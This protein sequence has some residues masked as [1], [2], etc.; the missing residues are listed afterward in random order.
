M[1]PPILKLELTIPEI[2]MMFVLFQ[3]ARQDKHSFDEINLL[4]RK[5]QEQGKPQIEALAIKRDT[6][7]VLKQVKARKPKT[8]KAA[9]VVE[10]QQSEPVVEI[11]DLS[12]LKLD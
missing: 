9:P 7:A 1:T 11:P 10:K 5:I 4:M 6:D 8:P 12:D 2:D 3:T